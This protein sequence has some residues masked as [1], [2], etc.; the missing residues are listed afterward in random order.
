MK[1]YDI[2]VAG[3]GC[4]G[5]TAAIQAAR[6]GAKT[7]LIERNGMCGGIMT[8]GG[9][10]EIG[11]FWADGKQV[12]KGIGYELVERL[13]E[14]D[15]AQLPSTIAPGRPHWEY[16]VK[17]SI[18]LAAAL[19][20]QMLLEAG[21]EIAYEQT[22]CHAETERD[23]KGSRI[24]KILITTKSGLQEATAAFYIDATGDGDLSFLAG[25]DY[26]LGEKKDGKTIL[27]PGTIRAFLGD[28]R[29]TDDECASV[30][31]ILQELIEKGELLPTDT[32]LE[33]YRRLTSL[34]YNNINHIQ[35]FNG[36]DSTDK[37]RG[38][39]EGRRSVMRLI[40][41]L[42]KAG[43]KP[44]LNATIAPETA[45]RETRRIICDTY[46]TAEDY[47]TA[48]RYPDSV[49]TTY[50]PID[51]HQDGANQIKQQFL[52]EGRIPT[53]PLS[54]MTPKGINNLFVA[55]RCISGDR[56]AASAY[57][58]KASCM[59]M[60]QACGAAAAQAVKNNLTETRAIDI[61]ALRTTLLANGAII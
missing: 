29:P 9:N 15:G 18:P 38:N 55:G 30:D 39:I 12:I 59:A 4:A 14:I 21:V 5:F 58:V 6:L 61:A 41:A 17:V 57:R 37:T 23:D 24:K 13:A 50:Y 1:R 8:V 56:L 20:D 32:H 49:C 25:A 36:A 31:A 60:G 45:M 19:I 42:R 22:V 3:G 52:E 34:A 53:I 27:Q 47:L 11:Q 40:T 44:N 7:L 16:G 33:S 46:I 26:E 10:N 43:V 28:K 51:L 35:G 2:I 48:R 54:A